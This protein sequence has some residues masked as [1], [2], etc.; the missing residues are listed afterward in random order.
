MSV[1]AVL[2]LAQPILAQYVGATFGFNYETYELTGPYPAATENMPLYNPDPNN[3][4][5]TWDTWVRE[6]GQAGVDFLAPNLRG[7]SPITA[8]SPAGMAP[9]LT[10]LSNTGFA[11]QIKIAAFD[12]NA[13][14]WTAQWQNAGHTGPFDISD[15]ANWTYIYD[16]NYKIF[17]QTIPDANRFKING[18][19]VIIIWTGNSAT[20]TNEQGNY[21]RAMTYVRQKCQADFGFNPYI[22]V[23]QDALNNDT[24]LAAVVDGAHSWSGGGT[25]TLTT[26]NNTK[27]GVAFPGLYASTASNFRDPNHG[28]TLQTALTNTVGAGALIT[29][30]EGFT[31]YEED[32]A[33]FRVRNLD[34]S[35]NTLTYADTLY[36]Y[37]NQRLDIIRQHSQHPFL[38]NLLFEAEGADYFGGAA[39]GNGKTNFYRNGTI[40]IE[41]TSDTG[42]G[43]DVGWMQPDEWLEWENVPLNSNPHFLVR[44][45][46]PNSGRTAHL[47]I[48]GVAEPSQTLPDTGGWQT[49]T[50]YDFGA[51]GTYTNSY[52][53]VRI[54]FDN[55]GVNF[56]WWQL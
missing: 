41:T 18:R 23:N 7:A 2:G 25:W 20:V 17:F 14:S 54:V 11:S 32:A 12:D 46:T 29:L 21:S 39:G 35:G 24:T 30:I 26:F 51:Y 40:A 47:V 50:T 15:S 49:W 3:T 34:S 55:G 1:A 31:D 27:T 53:T 19:P 13:A 28:T 56:N 45:A 8:W 42:G 36:D 44:I 10:A 38:G 6:A 4:N 37:P 16:T 52:H 33:L 43:F 22:I 48:D 9:I 5:L